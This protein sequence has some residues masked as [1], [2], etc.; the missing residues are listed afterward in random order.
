MSGVS[1]SGAS[2]RTG[3]M[4]LISASN[5]C[6]LPM[7]KA[8]TGDGNSHCLTSLL[9]SPPGS[10]TAYGPVSRAA[11]SNPIQSNEYN[12]SRPRAS[13]SVSF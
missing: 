9:I 8:V 3:N 4:R 13:I 2:R 10:V 7:T 1:A 11:V 12:G 5:R 6:N